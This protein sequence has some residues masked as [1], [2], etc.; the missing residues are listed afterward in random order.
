MQYLSITCEALTWILNAEQA[1]EE[2]KIKTER[3]ARRKSLRI[4][5]LA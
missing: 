3:H 5:G 4:Q 1:D 2:I